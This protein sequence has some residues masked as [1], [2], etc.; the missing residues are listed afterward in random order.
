M[1]DTPRVEFLDAAIDDLRRL[2]RKDPQIVRQ[3]LKKCLL[4]QRAPN[5]G[6]D[7]LGDLIGFRKLVVGNRTW[8]I[9]W[10][11]K[12]GDNNAI[13]V[14]EVWA[15]G[16]RKDGE[17]YKEIEQRLATLPRN[18]PTRSLL[19]VVAML[20]MSTPVEMPEHAGGDPV[21]EWLDR[22]L[23]IRLGIPT[24]VIDAMTATEARSIW[25]QRF[26]D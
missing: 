22:L 6:E 20:G 7:L 12:H 1:P 14:A 23:R 5:A 10:R 11:N 9:V 24:N 3:V 8:R 19:E 2:H 16:V 4:I 26:S 25:D 17:V 13:E 15:V 21:P 18:H